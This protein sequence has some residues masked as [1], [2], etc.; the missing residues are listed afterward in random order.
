MSENEE[1]STVQSTP[2]KT[3]DAK[4]LAKLVIRDG[5]TF[6]ASAIQAGYAPSTASKGAKFL[7][8]ESAEVAEAFATETEAISTLALKKLKPSAIKRLAYEIEN[9]RSSLGM[10][11]IELA[12]RFR[13]SDWWVHNNEVQVGIF[14]S[15]GSVG[16]GEVSQTIE[17]YRQEEE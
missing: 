17:A 13:E 12:G 16:A 7:C 8:N 1:N 6:K 4:L 10:K 14:N 15:I 2:A 5:K 3:R 11:A 9:T